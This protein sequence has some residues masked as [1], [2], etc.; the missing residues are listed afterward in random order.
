MVLADREG[1]VAHTW[2]LD[3]PPAHSVYLL[4]SGNLLR[5]AQVSAHPIFPGTHGGRLQEFSWDGELLWEWSIPAGATSLFGAVWSSSRY[6][7][8][9]FPSPSESIR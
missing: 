6:Q 9:N 2:D 5:C 8:S 4:E 1:T 3:P 7:C